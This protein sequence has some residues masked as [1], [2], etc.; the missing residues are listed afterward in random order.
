MSKSVVHRVFEGERLLLTRRRWRLRP[1]QHRA[2]QAQKRQDLSHGAHRRPLRPA[3]LRVWAITSSNS[4][5]NSSWTLSFA[6]ASAFCP[7]EVARYTWRRL[8]PAPT[9]LQRSSPLLSKPC[10][11]GYIVPALSLYPWRPSSSIISSPKIG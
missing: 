8:R 5:L 1:N 10:S 4:S 7:A 6:S 3:V 9:T 2:K 11:S